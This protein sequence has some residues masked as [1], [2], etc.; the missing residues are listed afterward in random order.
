MQLTTEDMQHLRKELRELRLW[1]GGDEGE[2]DRIEGP[3]VVMT[4]IGYVNLWSDGEVDFHGTTIATVSIDD[5]IVEG[6]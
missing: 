6:E 5:T 4:S 1:W 3:E 2:L